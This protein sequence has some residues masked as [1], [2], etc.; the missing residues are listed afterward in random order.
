MN[1]NTKPAAE[2]PAIDRIMT[3][4]EAKHRANNPRKSDEQVYTH[5]RDMCLSISSIISQADPRSI[6]HLSAAKFTAKAQEYGEKIAELLKPSA[7]LP[8]PDP[9]TIRAALGKQEDAV[10]KIMPSLGTTAGP[11]G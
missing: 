6:N 5:M 3:D 9:S 1:K 7:P 4:A 8:A 11:R 10:K 2:M